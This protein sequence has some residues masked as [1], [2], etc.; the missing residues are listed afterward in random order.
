MAYSESTAA[1][2]EDYL[3]AKNVAHSSKKMF[4]GLCF[5]VDDKMLV[6]LIG[7]QL[8]ARIGPDN[9]E[10][11]VAKPH[12]DA[13]D[14]TGREMKG[15]VYVNPDGLVNDEDLQL[16]LDLALEYNPKAKSSKKKK[17]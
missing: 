9:Y 16:W 12:V 7:E 4:G 13:M 8:M 11:S 3:T 5:L 17:N 2:I 15:Y 10:E 14:F 1:R 6:G